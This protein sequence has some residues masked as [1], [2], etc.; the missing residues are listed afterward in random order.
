MARHQGGLTWHNTVGATCNTVIHADGIMA[1][2]RR[3]GHHFCGAATWF[4]EIS[5][6]LT[7]EPVRQ[8][9]PSRKANEIVR[10][11]ALEGRSQKVERFVEDVQT[12]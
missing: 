3:L 2:Q 11:W 4:R 8:R 7:A 9:M 6:V 5:Q 1:W 10:P 12:P